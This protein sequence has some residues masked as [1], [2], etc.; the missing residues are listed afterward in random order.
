MVLLAAY[1]GDLNRS[2][3]EDLGARCT[4]LR[5]ARRAGPF[6]GLGTPCAYLL[7]DALRVASSLAIGADEVLDLARRA[8]RRD[9][10]REAEAASSGPRERRH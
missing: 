5:Q 8:P 4:I 3:L 1:N 6:T 7:D 2:R 10:G 9:H